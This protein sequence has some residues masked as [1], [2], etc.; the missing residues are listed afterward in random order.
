MVKIALKVKANL[1][2]VT[3]LKPA[4]DDFEWTIKIKCNN[5]N[6]SSDKWHSLTIKETYE[7]KG[8]RGDAHFVYKCKFCSNQSSILILPETIQSY[9]DDDSPK[10]KTMVVFDCR[11]IEPIEYQPRDGFVCQGIESGRVF[12]SVEFQDNEWV[13]YDDKANQ[14][15]G[16]YEFESKFERS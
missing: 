13:D 3:N 12:S 4:N 1:E 15:V 9:S 11:G 14:S 7:L 8:G 6:E 16:I 10:L 5:C 2:N